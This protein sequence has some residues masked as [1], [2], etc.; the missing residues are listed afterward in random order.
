MTKN[1]SNFHALL[2]FRV[3]IDV[4]DSTLGEHLSTAARNAMYTSSVIQNEIIAGLQTVLGTSIQASQ[5]FRIVSLVN[6]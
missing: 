1:H 5:W 6:L 3:A 4:G 2:K